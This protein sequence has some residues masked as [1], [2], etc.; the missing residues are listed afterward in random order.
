MSSGLPGV[1][2]PFHA[3]RRKAWYSGECRDARIKLPATH[4]APLFAASEAPP[5]APRGSPIGSAMRS[6]MRGAGALALSVALG[7]R[8]SRGTSWLS[9]SSAPPIRWPPSDRLERIVL[10]PISQ[11]RHCIRSH[12][13]REEKESRWGALSTIRCTRRPPLARQPRAGRNRMPLVLEREPAGKLVRR[14]GSGQR[15]LLRPKRP[16]VS[17]RRQATAVTRFLMRGI[18]SVAPSVNSAEVLGQHQPPA[19]HASQTVLTH[20][21]TVPVDHCYPPA[22]ITCFEREKL[23]MHR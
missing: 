21:I 23:G 11:G 18:L 20:C 10:A 22:R 14:P 12:A 7:E 2:L 16:W 13:Q 1:W 17:G 5:D 4:D 19:L 8:W 9:F 3:H 6:E 15:F